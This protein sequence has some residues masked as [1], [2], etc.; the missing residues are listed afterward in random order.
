[1]CTS[2]TNL[3][4]LQAYE[5]LPT[6]AD[7]LQKNPGPYQNPVTTMVSILRFLW[8]LGLWFQSVLFLALLWTVL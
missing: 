8:I 5:F 6:I 3:T 7:A 4:I 2:Y 1:M